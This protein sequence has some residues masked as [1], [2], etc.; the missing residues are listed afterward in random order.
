M[1]KLGQ[2]GFLEGAEQEVIDWNDAF[3][4]N[5]ESGKQPQMFAFLFC[6]VL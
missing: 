5:S 1:F 4:L 2:V 3:I 6:K